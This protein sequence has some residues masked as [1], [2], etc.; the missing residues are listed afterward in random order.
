M[1]SQIVGECAPGTPP[2]EL[3]YGAKR[4]MLES[5]LRGSKA[6]AREIARLLD[7]PEDE[8]FSSEEIL[9]RVERE[10][11]VSYL[12]T[13]ASFGKGSDL[14]LHAARFAIRLGGDVNAFSSGVPE[15]GTAL[16][17]AIQVY[18]HDHPKCL[19]L[20]SL[21]L[22]EGKGDLRIPTIGFGD[23]SPINKAAFKGCSRGIER[24][25]MVPVGERRNM[26]HTDL[27]KHG[28]TPL[29]NATLESYAHFGF[30][31]TKIARLL[32]EEDPVSAS[33]RDKDGKY[34]ADLARSKE[35]KEILSTFS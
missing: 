21:F 25:L 34:P 16:H 19:E 17:K 4:K 20:L 31:Y 3:L 26:T 10:N 7:L 30:N 2:S 14:G 32:L 9:S 8:L 27:D 18:E 1:I 33:V 13:I 23:M 5:A 29:H 24:G 28:R 35:M 15:E 11:L 6:S 22:S 12:H